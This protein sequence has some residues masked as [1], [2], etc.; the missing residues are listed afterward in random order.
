MKVRL[1]SEA[2]SYIARETRYLKERSLAGA[3]SF[4]RVVQ[5]ARQ[6][7]ADFPESGFADSAISL[8][9][10]RRVLVG[11]YL[12]DYDLIDETVWIQNVKSSVNTPIIKVEDDTDYEVEVD[13]PATRGPDER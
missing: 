2:R 13:P 3:D 12:F 8:T 4:K 6:L 10:A 5:R 9:G 1:S 11:T 7:V